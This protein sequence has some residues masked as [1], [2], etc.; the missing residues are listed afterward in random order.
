MSRCFPYP[1][2][3]YERKNG[4]L[5]ETLINSIKLQK[6]R[7]KA[8]KEKRKEKKREKKEKEREG[9]KAKNACVED[10][11]LKHE[12][13]HKNERGKIENV[14]G[15]HP[16]TSEE[17]AEQL[18]K[19]SLTEEYGQ[20]VS[21]QNSYDTSDSTQNSHNRKK[22]NLSSDSRHNNHG[23]IFR[24][25]LKQKD[26]EIL[27]SKELPD[28]NSSR[29]DLILQGKNE[30]SPRLGEGKQCSTS[31]RQQQFSTTGRTPISR[32]E[33]LREKNQEILATNKLVRSN[34]QNTGLHS[35]GKYEISQKINEVQ[36]CPT[37]GRT[38]IV[39][40]KYENDPKACEEQTTSGRMGVQTPEIASSREKNQEILPTNK[41]VRSNLRN[42]D[43]HS[44]GK[45]EI[46]Q[47]INEVQQHC[48][49]LGRTAI[50]QEK[51]ENDPRPCEEQTTTRR[52]GVQTPEIA[53]CSRKSGSKMKKRESPYGD[54]LENW[55][56]PPIENYVTDFDDQEWLFQ[57]HS[58]PE[59]EPKRFKPSNDGLCQ[60]STTFWPRACYF[61]EADIHALPY[62]VPF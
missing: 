59:R 5:D 20:P 48:P 6:E 51:Q 21:S 41:L 49:T 1:P 43:L 11:K 17:E 44:Q 8:K 29:T 31:G 40:E 2:P 25:R 18:E 42:T 3:G 45:Y 38:T 39:Q 23:S 53:E 13:R 12:K 58:K 7:E 52:T 34:L 10:K 62:T 55:V 46:S 32:Q 15:N 24:I 33:S 37:L 57:K 61:A 50:V 14:V 60:G 19:S 4:A 36:H 9:E 26:Q 22:H 47:N 28:P 56:P 16:K 30:I 54:L 27:P 35:Q